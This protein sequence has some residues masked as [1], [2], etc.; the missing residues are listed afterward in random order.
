[1]SVYDYDMTKHADEEEDHDQ[2]QQR[3]IFN[4]NIRE[5]GWLITFSYDSCRN[6]IFGFY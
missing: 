5:G 2:Q 4:I 6:H 3:Y 1:M